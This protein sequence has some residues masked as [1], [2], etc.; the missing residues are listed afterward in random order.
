M[1][2]RYAS[3]L[4]VGLLAAGPGATRAIAQSESGGAS[5]EGAVHG[6]DGKAVAN[7][8]VRITATATGY[9]RAVA[10]RA[11]GRFIAPLLPVGRYAVEVTAGG[12]VDARR[13]GVL[14]RVG[15]TQTVDIDLKAAASEQITVSTETGLIDQAD[16]A[17]SLT[18][19]P[20]AISD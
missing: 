13:D 19:D 1:R 11:D 20:R 15:T 14:L 2:R 3:L 8:S 17:G 18:I 12:F 16:P 5:L 7:A 4:L 9:A 10:T 6:P